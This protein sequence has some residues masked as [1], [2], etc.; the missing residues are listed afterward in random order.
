VVS[1]PSPR[2]PLSLPRT[3]PADD[4]ARLGTALARFA[5]SRRALLSLLLEAGLRAMEAV[6][7]CVRDI[8][9]ATRGQEAVSARGTS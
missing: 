8:D 5:L 6:E 7:P 4:L 1:A 2:V 3:I 9:L